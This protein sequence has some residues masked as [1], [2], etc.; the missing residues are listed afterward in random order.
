MFTFIKKFFEKKTYV[1]NLKTKEIHDMER[2][3]KNCQLPLIINT[4]YITVSQYKDYLKKEG[5]DGCRW[6]NKTDNKG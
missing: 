6:C 2:I 4:K 1:I 3:H 5:Y